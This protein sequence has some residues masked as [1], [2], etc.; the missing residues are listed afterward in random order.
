M[1]L[2][3]AIKVVEAMQLWR[4]G[5]APYV[6]AEGFVTAMPHT[7]KEFSESIDALLGAV[8]GA[9]W[10]HPD[11]A[12]TLNKKPENVFVMRDDG[13]IR[14]GY[15]VRENLWIYGTGSSLEHHEVVGW[16]KIPALPFEESK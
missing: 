6:D 4:R 16:M 15:R 3:E 5:Q 12:P 10:Q 2:K 9:A 11:S 8:R 7:P 1:N 13:D 14:T